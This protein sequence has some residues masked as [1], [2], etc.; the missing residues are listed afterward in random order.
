[1]TLQTCA[2][3]NFRSCRWG[4]ERTVK[5]AQ[6]VSEDPNRRERKFISKI[7][8]VS[9]TLSSV[10]ICLSSFCVFVELSACLCHSVCVSSVWLFVKRL[11]VCHFCLC[12]QSVCVSSVRLGVQCLSVCPVLACVSSVCPCVQSVCV[13]SV[14]LC[15]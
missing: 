12:F 5:R 11:S 4:D 15:V 10:Y 9:V 8:V 2:P 1:V 6:T 7:K 14:C 13:S 3:E